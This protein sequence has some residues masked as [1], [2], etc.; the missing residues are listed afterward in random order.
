MSTSFVHLRG[1]TTEYGN[2]AGIRDIDLEI[3]RGEMLVLLGPSGCGKTTLLRT[4]AGLAAPDSGTVMVDGD[5]ITSL[6]AAQRDM[7]MVFQTWALFPHL[8]VAQNVAYGLKTRRQAKSEITKAIGE[9]LELV[10]LAHLADRKPGQLSGGQQQRVALARAIVI[11][12]RVLLLDEPLS[13][14]DRRI[15]MELRSDLRR[16]Q[17]ELGVTGVYV[18]HDH[19]EALALGD[20]VAV[21]N[22]G[23]IVE[24]AAPRELFVRPRHRFTAHFLDAGTIVDVDGSEPGGALHTPLGSIA[25]LASAGEIAAI[26]IP[27]DAIALEVDGPGI[28]GTVVDLDYEQSS[29]TV[30]VQLSGSGILVKSAQPLSREL[31]SGQPIHVV[32]DLERAVP[33]AS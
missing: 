21:M 30:S 25:P 19:G 14:L 9:A 6:K 17:Q 7:G 20:R 12:P 27:A 28:P 3:R 11:N 15:R 10:Q 16:L 29:L 31:Y 24:I 13:A 26:C 4:I 18:T 32:A 8:T 2:G 22:E 5:D 1:L 23:R 33:L